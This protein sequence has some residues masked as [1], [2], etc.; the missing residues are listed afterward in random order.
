MSEKYWEQFIISF[1]IVAVAMAITW[2]LN[3]ALRRR[4]YARRA[5]DTYVLGDSI[6]NSITV[7]LDVKFSEAERRRILSEYSK[8][9]A[10][11]APAFNPNSTLDVRPIP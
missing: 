9:L 3:G 8:V 5:Y 4:W 2:E 11:Y 1:L 7:N 10:T 6:V